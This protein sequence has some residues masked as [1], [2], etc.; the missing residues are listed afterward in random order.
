M[1]K[2][3]AVVLSVVLICC[4][5]V[6]AFAAESPVATQKINVK[7]RKSNFTTVKPNADG[8]FD[9]IEGE[10]AVDGKADIEYTIDEGDVLTVKA[11]EEYGNFNSWSIY[12][13]VE[14]VEGT[15]AGVKKS[16]VVTLS[17]VLN[18]ATTTK[19]VEAVEG[20]DYEILG[21]NKNSKE[22]VLKL[23]TSVIVCANYDNVIT[24]PLVESNADDSASAP[25]T[26]DLAVVYAAVIMLA[27]VAFGFAAKKVY[28]K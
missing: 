28:S 13:V 21:G 19:V 8:T 14:A 25:Q 10:G 15:S 26:N 22:L 24:E 16:G 27:V 12:K 11:V 2:I 9:V 18:L 6:T 3:I 4:C 1:K 23:N 17:A 7:V 20:V 5:S